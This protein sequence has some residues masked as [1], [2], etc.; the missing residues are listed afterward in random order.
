M[1]ISKPFIV[2]VILF[3]LV[4]AFSIF[5][6]QSEGISGNFAQC[7]SQNNVKMYGAFWCP[8][9]ESQKEMFGKSWQYISYIECSLPDKSGQTQN[10][11]DEEINSYPT[12]E[13]N[14]GQRHEGAL[15]PLQLSQFSG[16]KIS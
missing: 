7:L 14:D 9:C 12:W 4:I 3:S 13:F 5:T 2:V 1:K 16:C 8:H 6:F 11:I 10:C 15:T